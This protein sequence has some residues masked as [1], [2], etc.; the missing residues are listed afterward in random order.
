MGEIRKPHPARPGVSVGQTLNYRDRHGRLQS[1]KVLR[2]EASWTQHWPEHASICLT[3]EH[4]TYSNGQA[5]IAPGDIC[6]M[7][8]AAVIAMIQ[9]A[10]GRLA[11][12]PERLRRL[13]AF[14]DYWTLDCY[15]PPAE[16]VEDVS[17]IVIAFLALASVAPE[18]A[19]R[20]A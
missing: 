10:A 6:A 15:T 5:H 16:V 19:A 12:D 18:D 7:D 13:R 20:N 8:R 9:T 3:V 4:P 2:I 17:Q 14:G 11:A 1:G